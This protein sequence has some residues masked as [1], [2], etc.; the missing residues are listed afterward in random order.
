M[1]VT[2]KYAVKDV[3][4]LKFYELTEGVKAELP[5]MEIDYLNSCQLTLE[6]ETVYA[7]AK[8]NNFISFGGSRTGTFT[9]S[10]QVITME[11]LAMMLGGTY[12]SGENKIKVTGD[13]PSKSYYIEGTFNMVDQSGQKALKKLV[14]SKCTPQASTDLTLSAT[15]VGEFQLVMDILVD[16]TNTLLTLE[17]S[18]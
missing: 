10:A 11:F 5:S 14:L 6:S 13:I 18:A 3:V 1:A 7:T 4:D 17:A 15:E 8:G 12:T 2:T 9:M 16:D